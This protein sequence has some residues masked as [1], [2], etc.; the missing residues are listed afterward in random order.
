MGWLRDTHGGETACQSAAPEFA[1]LRAYWENLRNGAT[2]PARADFNPREI[3]GLLEHTL[4][5]ERIAPGQARIRLAGMGL[6]DLMAMDLRGMPLFS[7]M[8]PS[9]REQFRPM[10]EAVF[11]RPAIVTMQLDS[12]KSVL[13]G[14]VK[15]QMMLLPLCGNSGQI[16]RAL[17]VFVIQG[18]PG[19]VPRRFDLTNAKLEPLAGDSTILPQI[20]TKLATA[21]GGAGPTQETDGPMVTAARTHLRLVH[22]RD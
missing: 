10:V 17:G 12:E 18:Q 8:A 4:L 13:R 22:S 15:A 20:G 7:V 6:C 5:L 2:V 21:V 3:A 19:R 16:D 11:A 14:T 1:Q 9:A